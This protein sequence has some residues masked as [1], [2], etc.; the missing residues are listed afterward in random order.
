MSEVLDV[1]RAPTVS[2]LPARSPGF[3]GQAQ[4]GGEVKADGDVRSICLYTVSVDPSGMGA[5]MVDLAA[6]FVRTADVSVMAWATE[7]GQRIL[8]RAA[9]V[10]ARTLPLPRPRDPSFADTIVEFLRIHPADVFH[11]HVGFGKE[12]FEGARAAHR[13]GVPAVIQTQH[14]P[15]LLGAYSQQAGFF[16]GLRHV[17][18]LIA[19][20]AAQRRTY[21]RIGVPCELFTTVP[22]GVRHRGPGP[23]R[24]AACA[25]VGLDPDRPIVLT[26]GRLRAMK[27]H[28][29]LIDAVPEL[30]A[31]FPGL[32]VVIIG[33]G[34]LHDGLTRQAAD[35]G[36]GQNVQ[37]TGHRTDARQLL[38]AADVFV[39]P[40]RHEA[41][42]LV[43]LEAMDAG[44]PVVATRVIG[45]EEIVVD[46]ETGLLVP[47]RDARSLAEAIGRLLADPALR[48]RFAEAGRRRYLERFT[49]VRMA[50]DTLA[51]YQ[52]ALQAAGGGRSRGGW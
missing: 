16:R 4:P 34:H 45:S 49:S 23:G 43:L 11:I 38:A 42:P 36:V 10:G 13:A 41:M 32:Q 26:V 3:S 51:V 28:R 40:S 33:H 35:L 17:D 46:G 48:A 20:S 5:H 21:E 47:P 39:L 6:E 30:V 31:R 1:R 22:N 14:L 29:H 37:L 9:A 50:A 2:R 18:R 24:T 25:A 27:G 52:R 8:D 19:V 7:P 44:L 12:N 15:W